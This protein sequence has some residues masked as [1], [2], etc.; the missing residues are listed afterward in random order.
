MLREAKTSKDLPQ[1][2]FSNKNVR[3]EKIRQ[4]RKINR[5]LKVGAAKRSARKRGG[6][7]DPS[8]KKKKG[9]GAKAPLVAKLAVCA[10]ENREP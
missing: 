1:S 5:R 4:T 10:K 7:G 8:Q 2:F 9:R 6:K 3:T